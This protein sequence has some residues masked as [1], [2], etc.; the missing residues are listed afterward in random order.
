[1]NADLPADRELRAMQ[2][3]F[4]GKLRNFP[5]FPEPPCRLGFLEFHL[6]NVVFEIAQ[7]IPR[8]NS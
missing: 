7:H 6:K 2:C 1:M 4:A 3:S 5:N 8:R